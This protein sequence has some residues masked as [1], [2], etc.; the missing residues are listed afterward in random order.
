MRIVDQP[1]NREYL[2]GFSQLRRDQPA[3]SKMVGKSSAFR[4]SSAPQLQSRPAAEAIGQKCSGRKACWD[5]Y[6]S[7]TGEPCR[8]D[9]GEGEAWYESMSGTPQFP[10]Q[11]LVARL[12]AASAPK[13][14]LPDKPS[15][16][17]RTGQFSRK[18]SRPK[19][20]THCYVVPMALLQEWMACCSPGKHARTEVRRGYEL[21][22]DQRADSVLQAFKHVWVQRKAS[23][24]QKCVYDLL[25]R[26]RDAASNECVC[27]IAGYEDVQEGSE[28]VWSDLG[29]P[30]KAEECFGTAFCI[31]DG[32]YK[33]RIRTRY[34]VKYKILAL[35][36]EKSRDGTGRLNPR[37]KARNSA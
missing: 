7:C 11:M 17:N 5:Q 15:P 3:K 31:L 1:S 37:L 14:S 2:G 16:I 18:E 27:K 9:D 20:Y 4:R 19:N 21:K 13:H 34:R 36:K 12:G 24:G 35:V 25:E 10:E 23:T 32:L 29:S 6:C 33:R 8:R 30:D 26:V 22:V 28:T